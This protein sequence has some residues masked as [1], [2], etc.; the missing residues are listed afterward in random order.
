MGVLV[1]VETGCLVG[2][3]VDKDDNIFEE[4]PYSKI[5]FDGFKI[6]NWD[7]ITFSIPLPKRIMA[8]TISEDPLYAKVITR[9]VLTDLGAKSDTLIL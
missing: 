7:I 5:K 3:A 4:H 6:P 1:D 2:S 9:I 8:K